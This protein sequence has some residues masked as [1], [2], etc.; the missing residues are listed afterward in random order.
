MTTDPLVDGRHVYEGTEYV[1]VIEFIED[2]LGV[3]A[4]EGGEPLPLGAALR[5]Q[6]RR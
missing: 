5:S 2:V 1:T 6:R 3:S 4:V